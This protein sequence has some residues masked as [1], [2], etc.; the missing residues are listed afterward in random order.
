MLSGPFSLTLESFRLSEKRFLLKQGYSRSSKNNIGTRV[1][2]GPFSL[3]QEAFHPSEKRFLLKRGYSHSSEN[4][5][6]IGVLSEPFSLKREKFRS[7]EGI[8][9]QARIFSLKLFLFFFFLVFS[10][11]CLILL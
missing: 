1:F 6:G 4:N 9:T 8:L 11:D 2:F 7:S 10:F 3:K 5:T